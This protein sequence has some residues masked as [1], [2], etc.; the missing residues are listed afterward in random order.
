[1]NNKDLVTR[2][3]EV[4]VSVLEEPTFTMD[5]NLK[6]GDIES[7]DSFNQINLM[8]AVEAEFVVEFDSDEIGTLLSVGSIL[9]ALSRR[10]TTEER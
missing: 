2:L 8:L 3:H 1:M 7:W 9:E 6:M 5:P 4:F 10:L